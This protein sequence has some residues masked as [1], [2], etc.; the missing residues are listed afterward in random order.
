MPLS[1]PECIAW[2]AGFMTESVAIVTFNV[3]TVIVFI[4]N[5][6]LR[7]RSMCLV[8]NLAVADMLVGG[9]TGVINLVFNGALCNFWK[10]NHSR[11]WDYILFSI[12]HL[13]LLTSITNLA[14]I[15]LERMYATFR[16]SRHRVIK[17]WIYGV[18]ITVTWVTGVL[19]STACTIAHYFPEGHDQGRIYLYLFCSF[20]SICLFVVCV[21]Y[22]C[23]VMKIYCGAHPQH[24][25]AVSRERKLTVTLLITTLVSLL[26]W[27]PYVSSTFL[28]YAT[29]SLSSLTFLTLRRLN[30]ALIALHFANSLVNPLL[31]TIRMPE[32]KRALVSLCRRQAEGQAAVIL[33][34]AL[35]VG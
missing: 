31:Y 5:R 18:L 22:A 29:D 17:K 21:S 4:K 19:V 20:T 2:L 11:I 15:S 8:I 14:A 35:Q 7:K 27:L 16:P 10:Y 9:C 34:H 13:F 33:L 26:M 12:Q 30:S 24:Y 3:L 23:I 28:Y 6:S 32:F 25:G 1:S